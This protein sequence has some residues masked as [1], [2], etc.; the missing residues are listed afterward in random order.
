[1]GDPL[2]Q[3]WGRV[4]D[5]MNR[6]KL[7]RGKLYDIAKQHE[8]LFRKVDQAPIVDLEMLDRVLAEQPPATFP[9]ATVDQ[10]TRLLEEVSAASAKKTRELVLAA[11]LAGDLRGVSDVQLE[12][13]RDAIDEK[14]GT[15]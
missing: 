3:R 8:G 10:F 9:T 6:S 15:R 11:G 5:G 13:L 2:S 12:A 1:M 4:R 14:G 7:S